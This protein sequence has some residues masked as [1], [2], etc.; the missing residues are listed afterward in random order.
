MPHLQEKFSISS[1]HPVKAKG[2]SIFK[3]Y[4]CL[5][6]LPR[7]FKRI[8]ANQPKNLQEHN[9]LTPSN[10]PAYHDACD[11]GDGH[12]DSHHGHHDGHGYY[13]VVDG[14]DHARY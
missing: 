2:S 12:R 8:N 5:L 11:R 4:Y 3:K 9:W 14:R 6:K 1:T 10:G 13:D 7:H